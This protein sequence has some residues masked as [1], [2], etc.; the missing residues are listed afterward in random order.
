ME[1]KTMTKEI[2]N[3]SNFP[4]NAKLPLISPTGQKESSILR[5]YVS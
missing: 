2:K 4:W 1:I 5:K 3:I